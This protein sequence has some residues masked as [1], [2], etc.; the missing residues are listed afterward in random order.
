MFSP[1]NTPLIISRQRRNAERLC[2][3]PSPGLLIFTA[4]FTLISTTIAARSAKNASRNRR[5]FAA[6]AVRMRS[7]SRRGSESNVTA[8]PPCGKKPQDDG[9]TAAKGQPEA[10]LAPRRRRAAAAQN[11]RLELLLP[12][13][14]LGVLAGSEFVDDVPAAAVAGAEDGRLVEREVPAERHAG[15]EQVARR[16]ARR[17]E[18]VLARAVP[19]LR[20]EGHPLQVADDVLRVLRG[21]EIRHHARMPDP[22]GLAGADGDGGVD[23]H[24]AQSGLD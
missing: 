23:V 13:T 24:V 8:A 5:G 18:E 15:R 20:D 21:S 16:V 19:G 6:C 9:G 7:A 17:A 12:G 2:C 4:Y 3:P 10:G 1:R 22:A 14:P 11:R